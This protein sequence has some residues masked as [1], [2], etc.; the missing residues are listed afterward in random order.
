MASHDEPAS[1]SQ[2]TAMGR[3]TAVT[4]IHSDVSYCKKKEVTSEFE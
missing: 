4:D 1:L 3:K 2:K